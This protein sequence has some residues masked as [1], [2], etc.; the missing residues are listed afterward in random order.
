[1]KRKRIK[2]EVFVNLDL[3]PGAMHTKDSARDIVD[4]MLKQ[5]LGHYSPA[6]KTTNYEVVYNPTYQEPSDD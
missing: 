2:L 1:M 5:S 4:T 3:I 6:V